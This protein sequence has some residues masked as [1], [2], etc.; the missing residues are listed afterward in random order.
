MVTRQYKL[1]YEAS[2]ERANIQVFE[3]RIEIQ[4]KGLRSAIVKGLPGT[5]ILRIKSIDGIVY[6]PTG[7]EFITAS[8]PHSETIDKAIKRE[9]Y[10][11]IG[12]HDKEAAQVL[13]NLIRSLL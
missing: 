2:F 3:N 7:I 10:I 13:V 11:P 4:H 9:N 8:M 12:K 5:I 1:I 6:S